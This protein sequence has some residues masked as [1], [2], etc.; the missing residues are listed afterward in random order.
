MRA[1][2]ATSRLEL[3]DISADIL[4]SEIRAMSVEC[5]RIQGINLAQGVCDI[6]PPSPVVEAAIAAIQNGHNIY[7]RLD[8][9][10]QLRAEIS[11][12]LLDY[13]GI[14]STPDSGILVTSGA[15]GAFLAACMALFNPGDEVL[16]FEPFYGYHQNTLQSQ[17]LTP[18]T[19]LLD[20]PHWTLDLDR[21]QRAVT[22][23]TRG[24][25]INTPCNPSGKVFGREELEAIAQVAEQHNLFVITDEIYEYFLCGDARHISF[26]SLPGMAERT[27]TISGFS[28]T[29]SITGWRLGYLTADPKWIPAI[30]Y[31]H[32]IAYVCAPSPLQYGAVA[33]LLE[34]P[35][36]YYVE[37]AKEY[38]QKRDELVEALIAAG[39]T[40]RR[41]REGTGA[42]S[43]GSNWRR[44]RCRN[45][46]LYRRKG[47][48]S[49]AILLCEKTERP[50][51]SLPT[52]TV[53]GLAAG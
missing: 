41:N 30:G 3:S 17:R 16:L 20:A 4:Q 10:F 18:V 2:A 7:T 33:G 12:K 25:V 50:N 45:R 46:F 40:S 21:L 53:F 11:K 44:R 51:R 26:A 34:L 43:S 28:K 37:L 19:V 9:I 42:K 39:A 38:E 31:F 24:I 22:S 8:G 27:I 13:N 6:D 15:T 32:D 36:G 1:A 47:R 52:A 14:T 49:A 48:R 5:D 35:S 23:K 29:F